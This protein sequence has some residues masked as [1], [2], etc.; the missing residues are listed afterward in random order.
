[1]SSS[2]LS[3][4]ASTDDTPLLEGLAIWSEGHE[5]AAYSPLS[6]YPIF[7]MDAH[8]NR[9]VLSELPERLNKKAEDFR[10]YNEY[11]D[12]LTEI[13]VINEASLVAQLLSGDTENL[14]T[15]QDCSQHPVKQLLHKVSGS[16]QDQCN[17]E[18]EDV[19]PNDLAAVP[20][21]MPEGQNIDSVKP[22]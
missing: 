17:G 9:G 16:V 8:L 19:K 4:A 15:S 14:P 20:K 18:L 3:L 13:Q 10:S 12:Y 21:E 11:N 5:H 1:V 2:S 7:N 6:Q 22:T